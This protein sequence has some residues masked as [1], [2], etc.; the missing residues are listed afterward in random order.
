MNSDRL[1]RSSLTLMMRS[2]TRRQLRPQGGKT[3]ILC[4]CW[5]PLTCDEMVRITR[6]MEVS[7]V[8]MVPLVFSCL[9]LKTDVLWSRNG[10][11][12]TRERHTDTLRKRIR[13][14]RKPPRHQKRLYPRCSHIHGFLFLVCPSHTST[15]YLYTHINTQTHTI[16]AVRLVP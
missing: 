15:L 2:R 5:F 11:S 10:A 14:A 6:Y 8:N 3:S 4:W 12:V 16:A 9:L 13:Q 1:R 7:S